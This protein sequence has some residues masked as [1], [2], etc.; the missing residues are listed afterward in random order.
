MSERKQQGDLWVKLI[1]KPIV[2]S[3]IPYIDAV[4]LVSIG[5]SGR[6]CSNTKL[7]SH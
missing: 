2:P 3:C 1:I 5:L 7:F 6:H 4:S